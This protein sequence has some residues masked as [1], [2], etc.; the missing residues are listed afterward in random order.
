MKRLFIITWGLSSYL[1]SASISHDEI[2][3]MIEKIKEERKGIALGR[4]EGT[5]NPFIIKSKASK[6]VEKPKE[7]GIPQPQKVE[8]NYTLDAILNHAAFINK[9]WYKK[10][11]NVGDYQV[12]YIGK[13][14]VNLESDGIS[15][16]LSLPSK[17]KNF[18]KLKKGYN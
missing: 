17:K 15:K 10:G 5:K 2:T 11:D 1:F 14:S 8:E 7:K 12:V 18:I 6:N 13:I 3:Q 4:L 16:T 9:K